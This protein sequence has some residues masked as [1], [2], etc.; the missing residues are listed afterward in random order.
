MKVSV[1]IPAYNEEERITDVIRA[2]LAQDYSDFE[3]IVVNNASTDNTEKI[4]RTFPVTV[5]SEERKGTSSARECGRLHAT[6]DIIAN[7]DADCLPDKGWLS[8]SVSYFNNPHIVGVSGPYDYYDAGFFL[9][10]YLWFGFVCRWIMDAFLQLPFFNYNGTLIGGNTFFRSSALAKA[11]GYDTSVVFFGDEASI[12]NRI[13]PYGKIIFSF[14][15]VMKTS[16]RRFKREGVFKM[17]YQYLS[18]MFGK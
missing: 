16:A 4:A 10:M 2:V 17:T 3:V 6:G 14:K 8:K 7:V 11:G 12:V 13:A 15:V 9:R 1:V 5:V 18:N